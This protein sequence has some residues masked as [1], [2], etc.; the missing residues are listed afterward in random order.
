M[1]KF[2]EKLIVAVKEAVEVAKCDHEMVL[3]HRP[4]TTARPTMDRYS[5]SRCGCV[6]SIPITKQSE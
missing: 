1:T 4:Q 2:G 6:M 3:L 5:C